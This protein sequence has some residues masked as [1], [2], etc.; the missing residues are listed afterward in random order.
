MAIKNDIQL[1]RDPNI[2][3]TDDIIAEGLREA[4]DAY[5]KFTADL[6][7]YGIT[8]LD[9]RYYNDGKAWL[10]KGEY[11]RT[12][13]RGAIKTTPIFWLSIF[14]GFFKVSFFFSSDLRDELLSLKISE[15]AKKIIGNTKAMGKK[16]RLM[17]V[18]FDI[19][20]VDQLSDI[21]E[22]IKLKKGK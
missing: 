22:L 15:D 4:N 1:L 12:T 18:I 20:D 2:Q 16:M 14:D 7:A 19:I 8:F 3:P 17:P 10:S 11:R 21:Y 6:P 9:F 13:A 5:V